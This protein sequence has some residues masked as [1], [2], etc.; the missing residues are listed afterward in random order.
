MP[1]PLQLKQIKCYINK[2][3]TISQANSAILLML[4]ILQEVFFYIIKEY[5]LQRETW[6]IER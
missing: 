4:N 6:H 2:S 1:Q 3:Y 5:L